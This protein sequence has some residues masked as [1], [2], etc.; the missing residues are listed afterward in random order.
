MTVFCG[1]EEVR[2]GKGNNPYKKGFFSNPYKN[3]EETSR[4]VDI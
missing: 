4:G 2:N 1:K 3:H